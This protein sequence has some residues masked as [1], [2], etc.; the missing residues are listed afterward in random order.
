MNIYD[1]V[2]QHFPDFK[3]DYLPWSEIPRVRILFSDE[4]IVNVKKKKDF[5]LEKILLQDD[6]NV[7][8]LFWSSSDIEISKKD[9]ADIKTT[10]LDKFINTSENQIFKLETNLFAHTYMTKIQLKDIIKY[11]DIIINNEVHELPNTEQMDFTM[12][13]FDDNFKYIVNIYSQE[14]IDISSY[15]KNILEGLYENF[16]NSYKILTDKY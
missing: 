7:L 6:L 8:F 16:S 14:G 1:K 12:F 5:L 13:M 15:N 2:F 3:I 11:T 4:N 10:G 9:V